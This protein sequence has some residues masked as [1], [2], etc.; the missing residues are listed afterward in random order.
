[1]QM[2]FALC[3]FS[4]LRMFLDKP[5]WS[6]PP[7]A[8]TAQ[9]LT[10]PPSGWAGNASSQGAPCPA[11]PGP[12]ARAPLLLLL[13]TWPFHHPVSLS[14][15]SDLWPGTADCRVTADR[16]A[17]PQADAVLVHHREISSNPRK[18]LPTSPRPPG[19]RWVW[20]SM[21]S[22][23]HCAQLKAL[24]GY[25]NLTM[26]YRRDSDIFTPYGWLEPWPG[27]PAS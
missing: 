10:T 15:C 14:R 13:W 23:S 25:F 22:P 9:S 21:E 8:N 26:S 16:S 27:Q 6:A 3:F 19:Q 17:Y 12:S 20:Y 5:L 4:Y 1:M 2:F 24:D 11:S 7:E 18:Q